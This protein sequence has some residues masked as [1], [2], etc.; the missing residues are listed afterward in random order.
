MFNHDL[1]FTSKDKLSEIE[2]RERKTNWHSVLRGRNDKLNN[3]NNDDYKYFNSIFENKSSRGIKTSF[4]KYNAYGFL[5][6]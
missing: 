6:K 1:F 3:Y 5:K 4:E 2:M